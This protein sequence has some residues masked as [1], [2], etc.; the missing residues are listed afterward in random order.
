MLRNLWSIAF[1]CALGA[2]I[3]NSAV[4]EEPA[5]TINT[6][7]PQPAPVEEDAQLHDVQ[8]LNAK[9]GWAV[10]EHGVIWHT[11]DGGQQW[12][13]QRSGVSFALRSVCF[14]TDQIGWAAGGGTIPYTQQSRGVVV[15]TTD[16]GQNWQ[17]ANESAI[18]QIYAMKFFGLKAGVVAGDT[19]PNSPAGISVTADGGKTWTAATGLRVRGWRAGDFRAVD[20]GLVSGKLGRIAVVTEGNVNPNLMTDLGLPG[21]H[22]VKFGVA[23]RAWAVGDGGM[24]RTTINGGVSWKG[25]AT[26]LPAEIRNTFDFRALA[27][28]GD[29]IWIA[30]RPGSV[31]WHSPDGG[32]NWQRQLT[33]ETT[34][35]TALSFS[36]ETDGAAVGALGM[37]LTTNDG[38]QTWRA[39]HG[40]Q[41]RAALLSLYTRQ[42]QISVNFQAQLAG[43]QGYRSVVSL[44]PRVDSGPGSEQT[45]LDARMHEAVVKAGGSAGDI[46]WRLPL[47]VPGLGKNS[48]RLWSEWMTITENRLPDILVG[49]LVTELRMWRP[50]VVVI[51]QP[52]DD[53]AVGHVLYKAVAKAVQAAADPTLFSAQ[54]ELNNLQPWQVKKI[55]ARLPDGSTGEAHIDPYQFLPQF[56]QSTHMATA[57][58]YGRL[59]TEQDRSVQREAYRLLKDCDIPPAGSKEARIPRGAFFGGIHLSPGGPA[60]RQLMPT[61]DD[62]E[63]ERK[64]AQK[65][66]QSRAY[67]DKFMDDPRMASQLP[68]QLNDFVNGL[69]DAEMAL[70]LAELITVYRNMGD[71]DLAETVATVLVEKFPN[72]PPAHEAMQWLLQLWTSSEVA[73]RRAREAEAGHERTSGDQ[74]R[75]ADQLRL[76]QRNR[77]RQRFDQLDSQSKQ[78]VLS[79]IRLVLEATQANHERSGSLSRAQTVR[80]MDARKN[81]F[82]ENLVR[83]NTRLNELDNV[84]NDTPQLQLA[85]GIENA[86]AEGVQQVQNTESRV[87]QFRMEERIKEWHTHATRMAKLMSEANPELFND[88]RTQFP[89]ASLYRRRGLP[90]E[91]DRIYRHFRQLTSDDPW[92]L[93]G[94]SEIWFS[95]P[96]VHPPKP[97]SLCVYTAQRPVLDG[98]LADSCWETA[99]EIP[100]NDGTDRDARSADRPFALMA[101]D[102]QFLYFAASF[103]REPDTPDDRPVNEGRTYDADLSHFDRVKLLLDVDR[104]HATYFTFA[105]DQRGWTADACWNDATWNPKYFVQ[106]GGDKK[107]WRIEVAIPWTE[108][109][110]QP[111][112]R[113]D[114]WNVGIIRTIPAVGIHSWTHP[115]SDTP[116]PETFGMLKFD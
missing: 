49:Q 64:I 33:G 6:A 110:P 116:R 40:G 83:L 58:A 62:M 79:D 29:K 89:L 59:S 80:G 30:G 91:A 52:A 17:V 100:L 60:R 5:G 36:S 10:G 103:P 94:G 101:Y 14:L 88:P 31:I 24:V 77:Q 114:V 27:V 32:K 63:I 42:D 1:V 57:R 35:I 70:Q 115:A 44:V 39:S 12:R 54:R 55:Y 82:A 93:S 81:D 26:P 9:L 45:D 78:S 21:L 15:K 2:C 71:W 109:V 87:S 85:G 38:G 90:G 20:R 41:R 19:D 61:T 106:A 28:R 95:A 47:D 66:K 67:L 98:V 23:S 53:D 99:Q 7:A 102:A 13:L 108:L 97:Y 113:N 105:F 73:W 96:R 68:G 65:Q 8:F 50:D 3:Y 25:P 4:A 104:D 56:R 86:A 74:Q 18:P 69:T 111:P 107:K 75:I 22:A 48:R 43:E 84:P 72:E 34:P 37:I 76:P 92:S 11:T 46:Y 16:G 112:S 51:N